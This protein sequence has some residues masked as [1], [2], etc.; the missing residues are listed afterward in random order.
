MSSQVTLNWIIFK[1]YMIIVIPAAFNVFLLLPYMDVISHMPLV[2][3]SS[4][5][6]L[7]L[8]H[9]LSTAKKKKKMKKVWL[10][11]W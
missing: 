1:K 6:S 8:L 10:V 9:C 2:G 3:Y 7:K 5:L 11:D 4:G